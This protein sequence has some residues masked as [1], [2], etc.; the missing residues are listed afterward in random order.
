AF[1]KQRVIGYAAAATILARI[2][3]ATCNYLMNYRFVFQSDAGVISSGKYALL[4]V[5]QMSLSALLVTAGISVFS[6]SPEVVIKIIVDTLL[7]FL[8][9]FIQRKFVF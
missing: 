1:L 4:A 2:I 6:S 8:S 9:Y 5:V 3:S 7:F